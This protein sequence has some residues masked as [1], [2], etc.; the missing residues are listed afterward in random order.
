[1]EKMQKMPSI[2]QRQFLIFNKIFNFP[3]SSEPKDRRGLSVRFVFEKKLKKAVRMRLAFAFC[4][5][6]VCV[7]HCVL[8]AVCD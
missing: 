5:V 7:W 8:C 1:M 3:R 2:T 4:R 6:C